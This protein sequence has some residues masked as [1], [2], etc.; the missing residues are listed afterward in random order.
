MTKVDIKRLDSVTK[1]DTTATER[2][3]DN[4]KA[5]QEAIENTLSRDGTGPNYMDAD[6]DMNSYRIINS[7]NPTEDNDIVN[8]KYVEERIGGAVEASKTAVSAASQA[9]NSAQSA[10]VSS[11]NAINTLRN[12]EE[13]LNNTIEYVDEAKESID[14]AITAATDEVKQAALDAAQDAINEAAATA[15]GI[16]LEYTNNELKPVLNEIASN[17]AESAENASESAGLAANESANAVISATDSQHYAEDSRIWAEGSDSEIKN[18]DGEHSSKVWSEM[19]K[20]SA[21]NAKSYADS[22][23][24]E[25]FVKTSGDQTIDGSVVL[26]GSGTQYVVQCFTSQAYNVTPTTSTG[27][28]KFQVRDKDGNYM[29]QVGCE[30][31]TDGRTVALLRA[32]SPVNSSNIAQLQVA[33][34]ADGSALTYAPTPP[35][36]DNSTQIATTAWVNNKH[37]VVSSLPSTLEEDTFYYISE[38]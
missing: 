35:A 10:L 3:N 22:L 13:Q 37:K 31:M 18:V 9:A 24:P 26:K 38:A 2:I 17:A 36:S 21:T 29:M 12:A 34:K 6:L 1:N 25:T 23:H 15:T 16:V 20:T 30:R 27:V 28:G 7:A 14:E 5:L 32:H 33:V 8:L 11:T 19:A 4:F